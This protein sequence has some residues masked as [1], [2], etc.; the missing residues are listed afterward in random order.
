TGPLSTAPRPGVPIRPSTPG[1]RPAGAPPSTQRYPPATPRP[2]G[3]SGPGQ[4]SGAPQGMRPTGAPQSYSPAGA[5]QGRPGG[6][7]GQGGRPGGPPSRF[8]QRP[9]SSGP[10]GRDNKAPVGGQRPGAGVPKAEPG[11]PLY[12]RKPPAR[13]GRPLFQK[14][15]PRAAR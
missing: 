3:V 14:R 11:K 13:G 9:G 2:G 5:P 4:R 10:G 12:A 1:S 8:P 15:H 7:P 6:A